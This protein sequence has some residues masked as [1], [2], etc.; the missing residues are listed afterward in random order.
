[1]FEPNVWYDDTAEEWRMIYTGGFDEPRLGY[2]TAPDVFGPWTKLPAGVGAGNNP[3]IGGDAGGWARSA[4]RGSIFFDDDGELYLYFAPAYGDTSDGIYVAHGS[5]PEALTVEATKAL[6]RDRAQ[7]CWVIKDGATYRML[8][9]YRLTAAGGD[10]WVTGYAEAASPL[11]PFTVVQEPVSGLEVGN[12]I[13]SIGWFAKQDDGTFVAWYHA[14]IAH[15]SYLPT[16]IYRATSPDCI[17]WTRSEDAIIRHGVLPE[18]VDQV[19]DVQAIVPAGAAGSFVG[20]GSPPTLPHLLAVWDGDD[21]PNSA[22]DIV[23]GYLPG[24]SI[25]P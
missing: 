20:G 7:N 2:A 18:E 14:S 17:R 13:W 16:D 25:G 6:T 1:M 22:G 24:L 3:I 12:G 21:N 8:F 19:A 15:Q 11:G 10:P 9:E 4:C 23:A 5:D